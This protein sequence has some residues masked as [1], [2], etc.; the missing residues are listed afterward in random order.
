MTKSFIDRDKIMKK[1]QYY[2]LSYNDRRSLMQHWR[3][4]HSTEDIKRGLG[5]STTA[6]YA[7][8]KR[9][10]LPTNLQTWRDSQPSLLGEGVTVKD[11][12]EVGAGIESNPN[13]SPQKQEKQEDGNKDSSSKLVPTFVKEEVKLE[14]EIQG[15]IKA[16]DLYKIIEL[17]RSN[18][19]IEIK[20]KG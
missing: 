10:D 17:A 5:L 6:F 13:L 8:L 12:T 14:V 2:K 4:I 3:L 9:L 1:N 16:E 11:M 15:K 7:L 20:L 18:D 19:D